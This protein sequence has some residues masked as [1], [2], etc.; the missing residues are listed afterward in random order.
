MPGQPE[1]VRVDRLAEQIPAEQW[2][3]AQIKEGAK[4]PIVADFAFLRAVALRDGLP[5][6]AVWVVFRRTRD[7]PPELKS[8]LSNAPPETPR[9]RL[10]WASGMR[11][12]VESAILECKR[13][14]GMDHYEVR[15]WIG[16][17]HHLTLSLLAHHFL[18]R[19]R[20]RLGKKITRADRA[21]SPPAIG[22][23][24]P[25]AP[26]GR[27]DGHRPHRLDSAPQLR[28]LLLAP[29]SQ[30]TPARHLLTN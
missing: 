19:L 6:P 26:L 1:P 7:D 25:Q 16:W 2:T 22:G 20:R 27:R 30:P 12:P 23:R 9:E 18:V 8:Y 11:W 29:P 10:I 24:S 15:G 21:P 13:E 3:L 5:G 4:G 17:H 28:R 14:L